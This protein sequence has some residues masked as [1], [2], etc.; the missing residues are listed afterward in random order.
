MEMRRFCR[1]QSVAVQLAGGGVAAT[2]LFMSACKSNDDSQKS[3]PPA[4]VSATAA[5]SADTAHAIAATM[6]AGGDVMSDSTSRRSPSSVG[7]WITDANVLSMLTMM[8]AKQIAAAKLELSAWHTDTVRAFAATIAA[9]HAE[10]QHSV[11]SVAQIIKLEPVAPAL[12]A[13][14]ADTM[15]AQID[16]L[17]S[18]HGGALDRGFLRQQTQ[19]Q[20][21]MVDY[22]AKLAGVAEH[23]ELQAL[24][25]TAAAQVA[26]QLSRARALQTAFAAADSAAHADSLAR[27]AA[28]DSVRQAR[29][30]A[31]RRRST[32]ER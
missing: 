24:L 10:L 23:P 9:G 32:H 30:A 12:S 19:S 5:A 1:V 20:A 2:M 17:S 18:L 29:E 6:E 4:V 3:P 15:Q 7:R 14:I 13:A 8:N 21:M 28:R 16:S 25:S 22:V 11:D 27:Q 26:S 31:R